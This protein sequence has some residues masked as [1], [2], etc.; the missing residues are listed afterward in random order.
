[1][2]EKSEKQL[3]HSTKQLNHNGN[4][5]GMHPNS[6]KN[7]TKR[8][9]WKPGESGNFKGQSITAR[10]EQM[11]SDVCSFDAKGR[12]WRDSLAEGGMRMALTTPVALNNLQDRHEGKVTQPIGGDTEHPLEVKASFR[13][14][15]PDGS[16]K[17]ARELLH[18]NS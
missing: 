14:I 15:M 16:E 3:N 8:D 13:F 1:M 18:D 10:Q 2:I 17:T 12:T 9:S 7:L 4:K 6:Q 11:M 5:R